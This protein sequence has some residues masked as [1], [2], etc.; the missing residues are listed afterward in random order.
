MT[1][2]FQT[3]ICAQEIFEKPESTSFKAYVKNAYYIYPAKNVLFGTI[4][5]KFFVSNSII[6]VFHKN[7][8]HTNVYILLQLNASNAKTKT[9]WL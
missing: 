6:F 1:L 8:S 4:E 7:T 5:R 9:S 3:Q 2:D